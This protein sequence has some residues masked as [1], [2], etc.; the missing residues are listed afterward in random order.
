MAEIDFLGSTANQYLMSSSEQY[1][2]A[3]GADNAFDGDTDS[4][5]ITLTG[6]FADGTGAAL[7][8]IW[9][10]IDISTMPK[11]LINVAFRKYLNLASPKTITVYGSDTGSFAGE[12]TDLGTDTA[13]EGA[14]SDWG[15]YF[16]FNASQ[17]VFSYYRIVFDVIYDTDSYDRLD[18]AEIRFVEEDNPG[19]PPSV[20]GTHRIITDMFYDN[21][22]A[23]HRV[24][25]DMLFSI[26]FELRPY[27]D[28]FH[29]LRLGAHW[30][31]GYGDKPLCHHVL[32]MHYWD[33]HIVRHIRDMKH[34]DLRV[35]RLTTDMYYH[36]PKVIRTV[37][38]IRYGINGEQ[39]RHFLD[40]GYDL[41][42][43]NVLRHVRDMRYMIQA[44]N[45][46]QIIG[47]RVTIGGR[48]VKCSHVN[49]E[50]SLDERYASCEL[51]LALQTDFVQVF[52]GEE[53]VVT[54]ILDGVEKDHH[55]KVDT[56]PR[57]SRPGQGQTVY[58]VTGLSK[59]MVLGSSWSRPLVGE[60]TGDAETVVNELHGKVGPVWWSPD[61]PPFPIRPE[62]PL[63]ANNEDAVSV[64]RKV[65]ASVG[66]KMQSDPDG[67][68]RIIPAY[69]VSVNKWPEAQ[70]DYI[71]TAR[72]FISQDETIKK[73]PGW[74][75][76]LVTNQQAVGNRTWSE[77]EQVSETVSKVLGFRVPW[78]GT[79]LTLT[80]TG[81]NWVGDPEYLGVVE[82]LYPPEEK[83]AEEVSF[84]GGAANSA[85]PIYGGLT[86]DWLEV[87][88]GTVDYN[89]AGQLT[90]EIIDGES[91]GHSR[92]AIRYLTRYHLWQ[93][94]DDKLETVQYILW[95]DEEES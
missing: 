32:D 64:I 36:I 29:S 89:E 50:Y 30:D 86:V 61:V 75:R 34:G 65:T 27:W 28:M 5:F 11:A 76:F 83:P 37:L 26:F 3:Y 72:E 82:E 88:L 85:R 33:A 24:T 8:L 53:I 2:T 79:L 15:A 77:V 49:V 66:A 51:H 35:H 41:M 25:T 63:Y 1:S 6:G 80:D 39:V 81:G 55:L 62:N 68:V 45:L 59:N 73:N 22:T 58:I 16:S 93:V 52:E 69:P 84:V 14:Y 18:S 21:L 42:S 95:V 71:L 67:S 10:Q 47:G 92:A 31:I 94:R 57:I 13:A 56:Q 20:V 7:R 17:T 60:Y 19:I 70:P 43:V 74:N 46:V 9:L 40:M 78:D 23:Q 87:E 90:A 4:R 38:D 48:R 44:G 54:T 91:R 12:E